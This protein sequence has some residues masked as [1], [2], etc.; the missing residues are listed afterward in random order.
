MEVHRPARYVA[1]V[2]ALTAGLTFLSL[3]ALRLQPEGQVSLVYP[4]TGLG[5]ALLWGFGVRWWPAVVLAQFLLSLRAS[6]SFAVAALVAAIEL[7][8]ILF[9]C[10]VVL[11][12]RVSRT[13]ERL[14]DLGIFVGAVFFTPVIGGL[15]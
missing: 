1:T 7:L 15:I 10:A 12:Y 8:V 4:A 9:F 6:N 11:R 2:V 3:V 13:L 14:R 5:A